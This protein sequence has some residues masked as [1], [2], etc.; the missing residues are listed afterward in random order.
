M[1]PVT[2]NFNAVCRNFERL[3]HVALE[4]FVYGYD[5]VG[6]TKDPRL[7]P[8]CES[9]T[10]ALG[11]TRFYQSPTVNVLHPNTQCRTPGTPFCSDDSKRARKERR[12]NRKYDVRLVPWG[13]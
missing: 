8:E 2:D 1:R 11:T 9:D 4:S 5:P 12:T 10:G 3:N 13:Q 6:C 7:C